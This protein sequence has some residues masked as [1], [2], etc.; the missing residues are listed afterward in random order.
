MGVLG[1]WQLLDPCSRP[2]KLQ[3]LEGKK[4]AIDILFLI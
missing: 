3:G 4:L 1:L 2:T